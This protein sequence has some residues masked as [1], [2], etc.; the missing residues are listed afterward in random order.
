MSATP[1]TVTSGNASSSPLVL[2]GSTSGEL[3]L[4]VSRDGTSTTDV[5][6]GVTDSASGTWTQVAA[7]PSSGTVGRRVEMWTRS[8]SPAITTVT[9]TYTGTQPMHAALL[10]IGGSTGIGSSTAAPV[11]TFQSASTT[12]TSPSLTTT[13][14]SMLAI[15]MCQANSNTQAQHVPG[16]GW[17]RGTTSTSG[18][19]WA[20]RNDLANATSAACQ[21]TLT[22]SV[23][24]GQAIAAYTAAAPTTPTVTVWNGTA[25]ASVASVTVWNGTTEI[26]ASV[27]Q[28]I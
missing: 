28:V 7:A 25:E 11:A 5:T 20:W 26:A 21:W 16:A 8:G 23:G 15:S 14:A 6:T 17:T 27:E 19:A 1:T 10:N 3:L 12:P 4:L 18:P 24:S 9:I 2:T 13:S 22:T